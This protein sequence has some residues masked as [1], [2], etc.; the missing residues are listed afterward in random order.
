[1]IAEWRAAAAAV[2]RVAGKAKRDDARI[3]AE[4]V[5]DRVRREWMFRAVFAAKEPKAFRFVAEDLA[6]CAAAGDALLEAEAEK[7]R[8]RTLAEEARKTEEARQRD[9][10]ARRRDES[11]REAAMPTEDRIRMYRDRAVARRKIGAVRE[12]EMLE[13]L[14]NDLEGKPNESPPK[15]DSML[16]AD[17]QVAALK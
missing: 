5:P 6:K 16:S 2:G 11:D 10:E 15:R 4:G 12:A 8:Q 1:M 7:E 13:R 14:A 17:E 9:D 3:I